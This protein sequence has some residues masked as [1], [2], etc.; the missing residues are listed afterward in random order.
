MYIYLCNF[1]CIYMYSICIR[2]VL[3]LYVTVYLQ[4]LLFAPQKVAKFASKEGR[5]VSSASVGSKG[6]EHPSETQHGNTS[7]VSEQWRNSDVSVPAGGN[8]AAQRK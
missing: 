7:V 2:M 1:I 5:A 8:R 3:L 4:L 6:G